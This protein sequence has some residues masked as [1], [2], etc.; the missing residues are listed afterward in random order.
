M[1]TLGHYH[2][3]PQLQERRIRKRG[4]NS[5]R[6]GL[7]ERGLHYEKTDLAQIAAVLVYR[8]TCQPRGTQHSGLFLGKLVPVASLHALQGQLSELVSGS[9]ALLSDCFIY[10]TFQPPFFK[11]SENES[12]LTQ[13]QIKCSVF[14]IFFYVF[15]SEGH[16]P[17]VCV[18]GGVKR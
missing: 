5:T 9:V 17:C 11:N 2:H 1:L 16:V 4:D 7:E 14:L 18:W 8:Q 10:V 15:W 13:I 3:S 12:C 6:N